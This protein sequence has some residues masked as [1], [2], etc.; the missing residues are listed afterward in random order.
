MCPA[1]RPGRRCDLAVLDR[2]V[3]EH[4]SENARNGVH[5][6]V[7]AR[8]QVVAE[9]VVHVRDP[10]RRRRA[11]CR[12][13]S[14]PGYGVRAC[15]LAAVDM[16]HARQRANSSTPAGAAARKRLRQQALAPE[17][18][19]D[20]DGS[21]D[22]QVV[23][24]DAMDHEDAGAD[25]L[26]AREVVED[27]GEGHHAH[28]EVR[29]LQ[30]RFPQPGEQAVAGRGEVGAERREPR[31]EDVAGAQDEQA[32]RDRGVVEGRP[33]EVGAARLLDQSLDLAVEL[34]PPGRDVD[35]AGGGRKR[36]AWGL[37][38]RRARLG[39]AARC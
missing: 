21:E 32:R 26:K 7:H 28:K 8:V 16:R 19:D 33:A 24:G 34:A 15:F 13:R 30:R 6:L 31:A 12:V 3:A 22:G 39:A 2:D 25:P 37:A 18:E 36:G 38:P 14:V 9:E 4:G 29:A 10:A 17:E 1:P 11:A 35:L 5:A 23:E 27:V 20:V